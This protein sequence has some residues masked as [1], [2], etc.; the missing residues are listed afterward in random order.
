[1]N[2]AIAY[3]VHNLHPGSIKLIQA[4][5]QQSHRKHHHASIIAMPEEV[6]EHDYVE[7]TTW[8][9][10]PLQSLSQTDIIMLALSKCHNASSH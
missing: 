5:N 7:L 3:V 6:A 1:M 10:I 4:I 8:L 2:T 9:I